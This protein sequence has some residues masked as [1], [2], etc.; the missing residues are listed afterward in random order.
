MSNKKSNKAKNQQRKENLAARSM[1]ARSEL[2]AVEAYLTW[3]GLS[4]EQRRKL[5][6]GGILNVETYQAVLSAV[7]PPKGKSFIDWVGES[8]LGVVDTYG[9]FVGILAIRMAEQMLNDFHAHMRG[10]SGS[11]LNEDLKALDGR[12]V[13]NAYRTLPLRDG[14]AYMASPYNFNTPEGR[15]WLDAAER[16]PGLAEGQ[17]VTYHLAA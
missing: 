3:D 11:N 15:I 2:L 16:S 6:T 1:T 8:G 9:D 4:E 10:E 13:Q 5:A 17:D 12:K 14:R 7:R